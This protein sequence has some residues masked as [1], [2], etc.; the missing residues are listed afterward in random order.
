[1]QVTWDPE[2]GEEVQRWTFDPDDVLR[3]DAKKIEKH[4]GG[5]WDAW[6]QGLRL[7]ETHARAVLLW[8]MMKTVHPSLRFEDVPDFRIRQLKVEMG[9]RELKELFERAKKMKLDADDREAFDAA[10]EIDMR[11]AMEREGIVGEVQVIEGKMAITS[12]TQDELLAD[13]PKAP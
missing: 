11:E 13:L 1:M 8:Y 3:S 5:A 7:S 10:F 2:N 6:V 12:E 4:Y 9:V